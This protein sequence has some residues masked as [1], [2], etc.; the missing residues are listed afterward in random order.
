MNRVKWIE[1]MVRLHIVIEL[2]RS[3]LNR[4]EYDEIFDKI[5]EGMADSWVYNCDQGYFDKEEQRFYID[6]YLV[7]LNDP[8]GKSLAKN[9]SEMIRF[10]ENV[11][12]ITLEAI[13]KNHTVKSEEPEKPEKPSVL[14]KIKWI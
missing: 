6:F 2:N 3:S 8:S 12:R 14:S 4:S 11:K 1:K 13:M 5:C 9:S 7:D 10:M